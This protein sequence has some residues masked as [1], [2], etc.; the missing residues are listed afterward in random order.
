MTFF[1][2]RP[3]LLSRRPLLLMTFFSRRPLLM[4]FFI[5]RPLLM[6][7]PFLVVLFSSVVVLF[8]WPFSVVVLFSHD[9]FQSFSSPSSSPHDLF[10]HY[11]LRNYALAPLALSRSSG[12][13]L[14]EKY[15]CRS[16]TLETLEVAE[17]HFGA[18]RLTLTT[19]YYVNKLRSFTTIIP[20]AFVCSTVQLIC[21]N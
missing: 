11:L 5:R 14:W 21:L 16:T 17:R 3:L 15:R 20:F 4:T 19:G 10:S 1:I 18:L 9:L 2:R 13:H 6:T 8:L 7:R 12:A